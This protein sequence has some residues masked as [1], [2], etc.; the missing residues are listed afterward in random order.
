MLRFVVLLGLA[1]LALLFDC[2][3]APLVEVH[4]CASSACLFAAVAS[5]AFSKNG[6]GFVAAAWF[7]LAADLGS[8]SR[9]GISTSC[10]ALVGYA[11]V[12]LR[13]SP[14][15]RS[16]TGQAMEL[17]VGAQA[18]SFG[19]ACFQRLFAGTDVAWSSVLGQ[20]LGVGG[21]TVLC[22][23]PFLITAVTAHGTPPSV[24]SAS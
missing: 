10:F 24:A 7:G 18:M 19:V 14:N 3:L 11:I 2:G 17:V 1:W 4:G 22:A 21:Y 9:L 20:A 5:I 15:A 8:T 12:R 6:Y 23:L 13:S 16:S